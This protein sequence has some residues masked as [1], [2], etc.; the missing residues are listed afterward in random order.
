MALIPSFSYSNLLQALS[1]LPLSFANANIMSFSL[2][3]VTYVWI[4]KYFVHL[5]CLYIWFQSWPLCTRQPVMGIISHRDLFS[6]L[7]VIGCLYF[8]SW[9][10]YRDDM[11]WKAEKWR[12][13]LSLWKKG[14]HYITR[15]IGQITSKWT[16][17]SSRKYFIYAL[18]FA[19][20]MCVL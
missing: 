12:S 14:G 7:T 16:D 17:N 18:K 4:F 13:N 1:F 8:F 19:Q 2:I 3:I 9:Q 5:Y 6:F 10:M 20:Y 11:N 15:D